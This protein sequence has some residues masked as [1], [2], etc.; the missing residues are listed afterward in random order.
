MISQNIINLAYVLAAV[1]FIFDLKWMAHPRTAVKG[2]R[3]GAL[4]MLI[5]IA[6]TMLSGNLEFNYI[7]IAIVTVRPHPYLYRYLTIFRFIDVG[8][9]SAE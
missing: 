1:L 5:A 2:N 3:V 9:R 7:L 4:A 8:L 6:A